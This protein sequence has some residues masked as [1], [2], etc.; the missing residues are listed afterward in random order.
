MALTVGL[1]KLV[2]PETKPL[3]YNGG[4]V[5]V[6]LT[7]PDDSLALEYLELSESSKAKS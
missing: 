3:A 5:L 4:T 7:P 2:A 1:T 6:Y